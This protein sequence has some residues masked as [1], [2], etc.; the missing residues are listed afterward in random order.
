V[1]IA[2]L[3]L[4]IWEFTTYPLHA[5]GNEVHELGFMHIERRPTPGRIYLYIC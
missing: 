5:I 2:G 3:K 1:K 4:A